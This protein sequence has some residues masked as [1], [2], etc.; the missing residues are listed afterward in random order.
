ME[1]MMQ[2]R[3]KKTSYKRRDR[4]IPTSWNIQ[5]YELKLLFSSP[6]K[7]FTLDRNLENDACNNFN[8]SLSHAFEANMHELHDQVK[9][10]HNFSSPKEKIIILQSQ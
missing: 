6:A 4:R 9:Y 3:E 8:E 5:L 2:Q 7:K 10:R 1:E